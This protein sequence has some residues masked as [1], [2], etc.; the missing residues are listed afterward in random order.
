M[1]AA[2]SVTIT[3]ALTGLGQS[4]SFSETFSTT[5]P[6]LAMYNYDTIAE[7][8]AEALDISDITTIELICMKNLDGTNYVEIDCNYTDTTFRASTKIEAGKTAVFKPSGTVYAKADTADV[9]V[10][11]LVIASA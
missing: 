4:V 9:L 7:T 10:E 3:A 6:T 1:G 5:T 2:C 8:A 11:Y